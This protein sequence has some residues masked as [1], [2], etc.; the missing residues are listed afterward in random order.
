MP[1]LRYW[2]YA[3]PPAY[4]LFLL[5]FQPADRPVMIASN[6][7]PDYPLKGAAVRLV[8][9]D[10]DTLAYVIR[11]ENA[12]RGRKAGLTD[13]RWFEKATGLRG[14]DPDRP[15]DFEVRDNTPVE[16]GTEWPLREFDAK[17]TEP[18]GGFT[19]RYFL[20][21]PPLALYLFRL[22]L[23][24]APGEGADVHPLLLDAH[25]FNIGCHAPTTPDEAALYA[26]FRHAL[27]VYAI[28]M[29][30]AQF[31]LMLLLDFGFPRGPHRLPTW[32]LVL[33]G[34]LY[35][36][37]CRFDVLPGLLVVASMAAADRRHLGMI[38][39][40]GL[41]L[42]L[43][44]A[45]KMYPLVLAPILLRFAARSWKEA[46]VWCACA[47]VPVVGSYGLMYLTDGIEGATVPLKFQLARD[48]E[49]DWCFYE[50]FLPKE[51]AYKTPA[52]SLARTLPVLLLSL[53]MCVRRPPDVFSLL[54]RST[55]AVIAFLTLSVF[56]SPQ[57]WQWLAVMLVPLCTRHRW[58][59][60]FVVALDLWTYLHFPLLFDCGGVFGDSS[61][62][63][64]DLH[65]LVRAQLWFAVAAVFAWI[66]VRS[67]RSGERGA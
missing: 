3:V 63:V 29:T 16:P 7:T 17:L 30:A 37:P 8:T 46:A 21:Y 12:A 65:V 55:I 51:L 34:F 4:L 32:L 41:L 48:P 52:M 23:I 2:Y 49:P 35:F 64:R 36:T 54:R 62:W 43:A 44:V 56:F 14:Y 45:L 18:G 5:C 20:E 15:D 1:L 60:G 67:E 24:G 66:E 53:L 47:A 27:R 22:G 31:G 13:K 11:A 33:P 10:C 50:K 6:T 58:L 25:Q 39:L 28:L 19:D 40:S 57:W 26:R 9:D 61:G 59:V 42:G 38:A